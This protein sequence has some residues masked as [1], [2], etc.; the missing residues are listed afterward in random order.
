MKKQ[1][2]TLDDKVVYLQ[3]KVP[4]GTGV[5]AHMTGGGVAWVH[6]VRF[7]RETWSIMADVRLTDGEIMK[8][9]VEWLFLRNFN[10]SI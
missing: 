1:K 4:S 2:R 7:Y 6:I 9:P 10:L 8:T 3:E 5:L